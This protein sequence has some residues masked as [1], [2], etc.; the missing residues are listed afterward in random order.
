MTEGISLKSP[1][2]FVHVR[3]RFRAR[4]HSCQLADTNPKRERGLEF[5]SSLTLRVSVKFAIHSRL[6]KI[7]VYRMAGPSTSVCEIRAGSASLEGASS[8]TSIVPLNQAP[9]FTAGIE[10]RPAGSRS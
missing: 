2:S 4:I 6:R 8:V 1:V 3:S 9:E 7:S 10:F 5:T